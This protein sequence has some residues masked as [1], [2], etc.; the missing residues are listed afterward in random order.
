MSTAVTRSWPHSQ[1]RALLKLGVRVQATRRIVVWQLALS[2]LLPHADGVSQLGKNFPQTRVDESSKFT[3][4]KARFAP[5]QKSSQC[6]TLHFAILTDVDP[7]YAGCWKQGAQTSG[8]STPGAVEGRCP[9][10]GCT[11]LVFAAVSGFDCFPVGQILL[12]N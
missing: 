11:V 1:P 8:A 3:S 2:W 5:S 10:I 6:T 12:A 4:Y 7:C 9:I